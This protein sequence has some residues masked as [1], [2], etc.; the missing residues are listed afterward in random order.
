MRRREFIRVL[1]LTAAWPLAARGQQA[2]Q[3][4][5]IGVLVN[6]PWPPLEGLRHG[7]R[8][9]GYV[10]GRDIH[11]EYRFAEGR[12]ERYPALAD[13]LVALQ[14]EVIVTQGTPSTL[15]AI[16]ATRSIPIVMSIGD[17]QGTGVVSNLARPGANVTGVSTQG[18]E[19]EGKRLQLLKELMPNL[20]RVAVLS[21][22]RNP[23]C[24]I[25][26]KQA[27][28]AAAALQVELDVVEAAEPGDLN[29][30]L[31][32]ITRRRPDA[33]LVIADAV[34]A[35]QRGRITE[36]MQ[37]QRLPAMYTY[38]EYVLSGGLVSYST[39]YFDLFRREAHFVD[40]ILKGAKPG[41]LPVELPTKFDLLINLK[42]ARSLGLTVPHTLLA[43]ADE[44]ID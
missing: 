8:E 27:E 38:R 16:N 4:R 43:R 41:D 32:E 6:D 9:L 20:S 11:I 40:K 5:R 10:E 22:P 31:L 15:A 29:G 2:N 42:A 1:G 3:L 14:V 34:L 36:F 7:L 18:A 28:A 13:E 12:V 30:A 19:A 39:S 33:A 25:A 35:G 23:Y 26:V 17:P 44:V 21:N 37:A 24:I